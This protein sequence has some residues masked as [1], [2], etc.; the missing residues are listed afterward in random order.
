MEEF[1]GKM[2]EELSMENLFDEILTPLR[3]DPTFIFLACA[4]MTA[5][6]AMTVFTMK[7]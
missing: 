6:C 3:R 7:R 4:A 1:E 2:R 5:S